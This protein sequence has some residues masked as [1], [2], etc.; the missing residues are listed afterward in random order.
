MGTNAAER[1]NQR[2]NP[3]VHSLDCSMNTLTD[4]GWAAVVDERSDANAQD[5]SMT[6]AIPAAPMPR[7][8][9][10]D[11]VRLVSPASTPQRELVAATVDYLEGLGLRVE[12]GNHVFDE[13]GYL[14]GTDE[15]RLADVNAALRDPGI[16]AII[17][18][19]GG[20]GAYR[21]ANGLDFVAARSN[22]KLLVGFSEIT[23]LHLALMRHCGWVGIHG[24]AWNEAFGR[25]AAES[26]IQAMFACEDITVQ[27][28]A[29]EPTAVLTTSGCAEGVL[30]GGNQDMIA[31]G[32]GWT[33]PS[34]D[35]AILLLEAVN[36]RLGHIDRQL[37]M[38]HNAGH[39]QGIRGVAI[40]QYTDCGSDA[41]TQGD[42]TTNDVLRQH[43]QKWNVP[44]LGG[45][46]IGHGANPVAVPLGTHA[47][48]D[49]D[50][51]TLVVQS[52]T[53]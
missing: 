4:S 21:I 7:L 53:C 19:R 39:L 24:A 44:V 45:L 52:A 17:T 2:D 6:R 31:T 13:L 10:G 20:K 3:T 42:W 49:A 23:I 15:D 35:G 46:P 30:I 29:D 11:R 38:L 47:V 48:L 9:P 12:L 26:F 22:P 51:Q 50:Q 37:T 41:T 36:M 25:Q 40:G 5:Q 8:L 14:A 34:F 43:L 1:L 18:T 32:A 28:S 16:R 27:P 33:L